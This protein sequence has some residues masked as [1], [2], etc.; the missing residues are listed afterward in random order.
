MARKIGKLLGECD[1]FDFLILKELRENAKISMRSLA[2][3]TGLHPNTLLQ[4][5]KKLEKD[6]IIVKYSAELNYAKLGYDLHAIIFVEVTHKAHKEWDVAK[7]LSSI[8]EILALYSITGD[9]DVVAIVKTKNNESLSK[10][11]QELN[12]RDYVTRTYTHVVLYAY[13]HSYEF[14]PFDGMITGGR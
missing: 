1:E 3:K 2:N 14:N 7:E 8:P 9:Y 11:I 4:R 6:G 5:I 12:K 13:K 10:L